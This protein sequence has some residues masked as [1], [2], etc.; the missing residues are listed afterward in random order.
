MHTFPTP[1]DESTIN[2][3][4][5]AFDAPTLLET[6]RRHDQLAASADSEGVLD[7]AYRTIDSPVGS[8][9]LAAT[10]DGLVRVAF[11]CEGHDAVLDNLA[12]VIS[13]RILRTTRRLDDSARQL[14][15]YL[16]GRR[17]QFELTLDLRLVSGFR[18][19]VLTHL[20][21]IRYGTTAS[22]ATLA[23]VAGNPTAVRAAASACSHNPLPLVIPC[24][25]IVK[26]DGSIGKYLGGVAAKQSLLTMELEHAT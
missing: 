16:D 15:D 25:R 13:P 21:E 18:R 26:S 7:I 19:T 20:R 12:T 5:A 4:L 9:L 10:P 24:H 8:L 23:K 2:D 17:T 6:G 14:D 22:Y 3:L 1:S 11:E